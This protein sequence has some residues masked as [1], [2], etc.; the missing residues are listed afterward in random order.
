M[1]T[2]SETDTSWL[3]L[4]ENKLLPIKPLNHFIEAWPLLLTQIQHQ[5]EYVLAIVGGGAASVELALAAHFSIQQVNSQAKTLLVFPETG[6]LATHPSKVRKRVAKRMH[7]AGIH[8]ISHR[9]S[10]TENGLLLSNGD[11]VVADRVLAATGARPAH[12]LTSS[13]LKLSDDGFVAVDAFQCSISHPHVFA[14]GDVC[15]RQD[16]SMMRSGVHAVHAGPVLAKNLLAAL[17]NGDYQSYLPRKSQL[18]LISCGEQYAVASLGAF[19]S[20]GHWVWRWKDYIDKR[21]VSSFSL[22]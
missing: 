2:G 20:Q 16:V 7:R 1:D 12:W 19:S 15:T 8:L 3:G 11:T 10:G 9:A 13:G 14:T 5:S 6:L 18:Y 4:L 21:F 17:S 22:T